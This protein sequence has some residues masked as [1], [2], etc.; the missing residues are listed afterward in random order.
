MSLF[1]TG[2]SS[3]P[4]L[5]IILTIGLLG[6][7][8]T[9][10]NPFVIAH[11]STTSNSLPRLL[12]LFISIADFLS[13]AVIAGNSIYRMALVEPPQC[14]NSKSGRFECSNTTPTTTEQWLGVLIAALKTLPNFLLSVLAICRWLQIR[15]PFLRP[16]Q[17]RRHVVLVTCFYLMYVFSLNTWSLVFRPGA[18]YTPLRQTVFNIAPWWD[19]G[20]RSTISICYLATDLL[21]N[22]PCYLSQLVSIATSA[23]S[24]NHL[25]S[26][27][28]PTATLD[29]RRSSSVKVL[30]ANFGGICYTLLSILHLALISRYCPICSLDKG[31]FAYAMV[32]ASVLPLVLSVFNPVV[33]LFF[34]PWNR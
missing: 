21:S 3:T 27:S 17:R 30:I 9:L 10:L 7:L 6:F 8:S 14:G 33:Y 13:G 32:N 34:T 12:Y 22:G 28:A 5:Y 20:G 26:P 24:I 29:R 2:G 23:L 18:F 31:V 16:P 1:S 15:S 19:D 4:D 11:S 25:L